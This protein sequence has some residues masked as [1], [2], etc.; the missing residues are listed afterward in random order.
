MLHP[1]VAH[2]FSCED[3]PCTADRSVGL[4]HL[5]HLQRSLAMSATVAGN[6]NSAST[7]KGLHLHQAAAAAPVL[8]L[9]CHML[10]LANLATPQ[11]SM[12]KKG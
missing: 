5:Y 10:P 12:R 6:R 4:V 7:Q 8:H 3:L 11:Q 2:T 1:A 9:G